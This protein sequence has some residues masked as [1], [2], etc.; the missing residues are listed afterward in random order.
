MVNTLPNPNWVRELLQQPTVE[1]QP[2]L[3]K[4]VA[5]LAL[6]LRVSG[7]KGFPLEVVN[8]IVDFHL[9]ACVTIGGEIMQS[10]KC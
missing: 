1:I 5:R 2:L 4:F 9:N 6:P 7:S 3:Q 10:F 8:P